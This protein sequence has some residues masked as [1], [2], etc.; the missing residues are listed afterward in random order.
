M[1]V[2]QASPV[3][4]QRHFYL[5]KTNLTRRKIRDERDEVSTDA[6]D[7]YMTPS[8]DWEIG[9]QFDFYET[10]RKFSCDVYGSAEQR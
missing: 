9:K 7:A 8:L 2:K 3:G 1:L 4:P 6:Y 10:S 5:S